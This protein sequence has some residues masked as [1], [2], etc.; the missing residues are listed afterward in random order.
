[1]L[2]DEFGIGNSLAST[3]II[4]QASIFGKTGTRKDAV[5]TLL[6]K[7]GPLGIKEI[8]HKTGF[9]RGTITAALNDK[10]IFANKEGKWYLISN[11][12]ILKEATH[13][14]IRTS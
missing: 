1:M 10:R 14:G 4:N 6:E 2:L 9:P 3:T 11:E 5:K 8:I 12:G 7:E 13:L